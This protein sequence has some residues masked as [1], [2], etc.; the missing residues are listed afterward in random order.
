MPNP[1]SFISR[2]VWSTG[3]AWGRGHAGGAGRKPWK[4]AAGGSRCPPVAW[5]PCG[6]EPLSRRDRAARHWAASCPRVAAVGAGGKSGP[7]SW[8]W[9]GPVAAAVALTHACACRRPPVRVRVLRQ[10]LP[11]R[12]HAEGP[13]AHPHRREALRVQRLRQEVQPQAPAGDPLP[14]PHRYVPRGPLV[15]PVLPGRSPGGDASSSRGEGVT[16]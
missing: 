10:L 4:R 13:Q 3:D 12:E 8:S 6:P 7:G 1:S 5:P 16:G 2:P 15:R 11:G 14:G 9:P